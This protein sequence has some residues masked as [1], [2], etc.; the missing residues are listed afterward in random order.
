[1]SGRNATWR[2]NWLLWTAVAIVCAALCLA[3]PLVR[4]E[5]RVDPG[6]AQVP[7]PP[8]GS[9]ESLTI[10][11]EVHEIAMN[12][13]P[14]PAIGYIN[15][16]FEVLIRIHAGVMPVKEVQVSLA[17]DP[18]Y[19]T[20]SREA[21][22][23]VLPEVISNTYDNE[24]GLI[25]VAARRTD[26]S[27]SGEFDLCKL[28]FRGVTYNIDGTMLS[29]RATPVV[30]GP[31]GETYSVNW[32]DG[33]VIV[34]GGLCVS[35]YYDMDANESQ[36]PDEPLLA[37]VVIE[38]AKENGP[39]VETYVTDGVS[40]PYCFEVEIGQTYVVTVLSYPEGYFR[41]GPQE[42]YIVADP[43]VP[44]NLDYALKK[45]YQ[46]FPICYHEYKPNGPQP[47][48]TIPPP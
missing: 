43:G 4:T 38:L 1:M 35:A 23:G 11:L 46:Y 10:S 41:V 29:S 12:P 20:V 16:E 22:F 45:F 47:E 28:Y 48:P 5:A 40:E 44:W 34:S 13:Y 42:S 17:F 9:A 3:L 37:D 33:T 15:T 25:D 26:G 6:T 8:Q 27:R 32:E 21:T 14:D 7:Q 30:L 24:L 19:I 39:V 2:G 36:G 18:D 31:N